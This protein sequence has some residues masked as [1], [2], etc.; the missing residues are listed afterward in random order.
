MNQRKTQSGARSQLPRRSHNALKKA[1]S[2]Q[3]YF[4]LDWQ[5][6]P[7]WISYYGP[8]WATLN[9]AAA[10]PG[11]PDIEA[12]APPT[13][14]YV[15]PSPETFGY[16]A[17]GNLTNDLRWQ[18][19]WDAENRLVTVQS[20][21]GPSM[22]ATLGLTAGMW[23][24]DFI[25]DAQGRRI[26][27]IISTAQAYFG[28]G[29]TYSWTPVQ[30]N[31]F[32]YDGW[33]LV[34][35]LTGKTPASST[36]LRSHTWGADLSGTAQGAGGVGGL[37]AMTYFGTQTTNCFAAYD[38][39]GNVSGLVNAADGA[40][41]ARYEHGPFGEELRLSGPIAA[42]SPIRFSS[43]YE[44]GETES[45]YYG[46]RFYHWAAGRWLSRDPAS[47]FGHRTLNHE[48][49]PSVVSDHGGLF[50]FCYNSPANAIDPKGEAVWWD[51]VAC[52]AALF[53]KFG[54]TFAG[55]AYG[56]W[57]SS[58]PSYPYGQCLN[59]C[60][61]KTRSPCELWKSFK[62]NPGEWVG[63]AAC[64]SC[65]VRAIKEIPRIRP[66]GCD[67]CPQFER[68]QCHCPSGA[69]PSYTVVRG[70]PCVA[71]LNYTLDMEEEWCPCT[72]AWN[73]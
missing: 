22:Y 68:C 40:T 49:F 12:I 60:L 70:A 13:H 73:K 39:N 59:D 56:C 8:V 44:D 28:N 36:L 33:N 31:R 58:S 42:A 7:G 69:T 65:G 15:A 1:I 62:G 23:K 30:T 27:K 17:D 48:R 3:Y 55:C 20:R 72:K 63:A 6:D 24:L 21:L 11:N 41:I 47:E 46:S 16:D 9:V 35:E 4:M 67:E 2:Y 29:W 18:Y 71:I 43:K 38:G 32:L 25:Y 57:E 14:V 61:T 54:G 34:A 52:A 66:P 45:L 50:G 51:C 19:T 5:F 37:L 64:I 26:Q 10:I 53:G